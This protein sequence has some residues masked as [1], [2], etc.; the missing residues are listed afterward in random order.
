MGCPRNLH[1]IVQL[2][3]AHTSL[4]NLP[5][6]AAGL[7]YADISLPLRGALARA[8]S[9]EGAQCNIIQVCRLRLWHFTGVLQ[10]HGWRFFWC[11]QPRQKMWK[12]CWGKG[13]AAQDCVLL[14]AC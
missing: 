1:E 13:C 12:P 2:V 5:C 10:A 8:A 6:P 9:Q 11:L 3:G 14:V 4:V 7:F